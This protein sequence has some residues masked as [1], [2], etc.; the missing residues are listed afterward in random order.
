MIFQFTE[1]FPEPTSVAD[2][3][4]RQTILQS[5]IACIERDL[6][7]PA[8]VN[9]QP[10]VVPPGQTWSYEGWRTKAE[11]ALRV[12]QGQE[13]LLSDWIRLQ[14][15]R[16]EQ[17]GRL[18]WEA[19]L[20]QLEREPESAGKLKSLIFDPVSVTAITES[21]MRK[22]MYDSLRKAADAA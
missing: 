9:Y 10:K 8:R 14:G 11:N 16:L 3:L 1:R 12:K 5:E 19:A 17:L 2:A 20:E 21:G 18:S 4:L 15:S 7:D 22:W 6:A 13:G